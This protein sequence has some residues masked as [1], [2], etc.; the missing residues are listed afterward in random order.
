MRL[1]GSIQGINSAATLWATASMGLAIG[2]GYYKLAGIVL[3]AVLAI[4]FLLHWV[5]NWIDSRSGVI[6]PHLTYHM[7]VSFI[8]S[9]ADC[10]RAIWSAFAAQPGV[11]ILRYSETGKDA[12]EAVLEVSFG[13]SEA[14]ARNLPILG[15]KIAG[16][17]GVTHAEWSQESKPEGE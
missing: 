17:Q 12:S 16:M 13:L 14:Q 2:A 3:V 9:V 4:Q 8:P 7:F 11:S 1:G 6:T 15:Q 5:A 10:I